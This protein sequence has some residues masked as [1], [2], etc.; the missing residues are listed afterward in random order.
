M[1]SFYLNNA[2][3]GNWMCSLPPV[4]QLSTES[5]DSAAKK[6][7]KTYRI[8]FLINGKI[9]ISQYNIFT[10]RIIIVRYRNEKA[11]EII[12]SR[13]ARLRCFDRAYLDAKDPEVPK[14]VAVQLVRRD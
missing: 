4:G 3:G 1:L 6:P 8:H 12:A 11:F 9:E 10:K 2:Q 13:L 5:A 14:Y 7:I